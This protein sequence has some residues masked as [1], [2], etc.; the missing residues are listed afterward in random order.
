MAGAVNAAMAHVRDFFD[1]RRVLGICSDPDK[2]TVYS[3][4]LLHRA[5]KTTLGGKRANPW[6]V[7]IWRWKVGADGRLLLAGR[8]CFFRGI[9]GRD[10]VL[11]VVTTTDELWAPD[12]GAEV[13]IELSKERMEP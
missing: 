8:G 5:G 4:M 7:G 13:V 10:E 11:P 9:I 12:P 6:R 1:E 2:K 3:L